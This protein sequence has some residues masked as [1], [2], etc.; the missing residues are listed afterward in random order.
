MKRPIMKIAGFAFVLVLI[1]LPSIAQ[2]TVHIQQ[3]SVPSKQNIFSIGSGAQYG[4]VFAHTESVQNTKGSYPY[5]VE[6]LLSWQRNDQKTWD[7]CNCYPRKGLLVA[8]YN[9]DNEI[10]GSG[11][12][13]AYFLEPTYRLNK[14]IFFSFKGAAGLAWLTNPYD[15]DH[16][17]E[18]MSYSTVVNMYTQ[19][20][21]G[22][23][24]RLNDKWW[25]NPT[26]NYQHI[27]NGGM[28]Q[29]NK[30]LNWPTAG[31]AV[32]Y[33]PRPVPYFS[34]ERSKEK[35][36][37]DQPIR[38]DIGVF[39]MGK[40][41]PTDSGNSKRAPIIGLQTQA[42]KQ[43]GRINALTA[44]VEISADR[45]LEMQLEKDSVEASAIRAAFLGGH[46]FLLGK[47]IFSQR[48]GVYFFDQTP[49]YDA[50]F[51]CWG[52]SYRVNKYLGIGLNLKA[53]K[54]VAEYIDLRFVYSFRGF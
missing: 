19:L 48:I 32:N 14:H 49:Y 3:S 1:S 52:I 30:G 17:S 5:G 46:E 7:L 36:W 21:L 47:F 37:K 43:V 18:N 53:H 33:I 38:W 34:G 12:A 16:N 25:I 9:Y 28:R 23:W 29:P 31:L 6:L 4:F 39:G 15:P 27:S 22:L 50:W 40:R 24:V 13:S 41:A 2:D 11:L 54:Q 45:S 8:Y 26:V 10:L 35:Y 42:A 20:G 51:H 44:G